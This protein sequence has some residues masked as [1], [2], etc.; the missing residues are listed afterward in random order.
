MKTVKVN[1]G[2]RSYQIHIQRGILDLVGQYVAGFRL[3]GRCLLITNETVGSLYA[4]TVEQSLAE[5]GFEVKTIVVEDSEKAKSLSVV[6]QLYQQACEFGIDRTSPIIALGGG[7]VGDLAGYVAATYMRGVPFFQVPTTL[8]A[9]VDSSVGGKVAVNYMVK[10][11]VGT[12]YQPWAVIID[13]ATLDSLPQLEFKSGI[14]EVIKYGVIQDAKLFSFL[15]NN[16]SGIQNLEPSSIEQIIYQSCSIKG[17][18]V[19][20]DELD[21]G[22]RTVLN[23]GHTFGHALEVA[24]GFEKIRHGEAVAIGMCMSA[25]LSELLGIMSKEDQF[26]LRNLVAAF[27]LPCY[28]PPEV[29]PNYLLEIMTRDKKNK[30]GRITIILPTAIGKVK[31]LQ[32]KQDELVRLFKQ[33]NK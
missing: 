33:L 25:Q 17:E 12:F 24:G 16:I 13:P 30:S 21:H 2:D 4:H 11:L 15:E 8:L 1:I 31:S 23:L 5:E 20:Q 7:V 22:L 27:G 19:S 3:H 32:F 6:E 29:D 10:N 9:Q 18:I 28:F 26:R 14:A